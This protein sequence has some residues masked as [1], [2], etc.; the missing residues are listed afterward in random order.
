MW[1]ARGW[2][3]RVAAHRYGH[4]IEALFGN[5]GA[6]VFCSRNFPVPTLADPVSRGK[7]V[8]E[9]VLGKGRCFP[10]VETCPVVVYAGGLSSPKMCVGGV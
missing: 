2:F 5:T 6:C 9:V 10:E 4:V 1:G 3:P 8:G 7:T